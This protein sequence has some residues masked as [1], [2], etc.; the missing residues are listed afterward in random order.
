MITNRMSKIAINGLDQLLPINGAQLTRRKVSSENER[1]ANRAIQVGEELTSSLKREY[2]L[3][4]KRVQTRY[5]SRTIRTH[6]SHQ[7][8]CVR[9]ANFSI[10][11]LFIIYMYLT[12]II[13]FIYYSIFYM[14]VFFILYFNI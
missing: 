13:S 12:L 3:K 1:D 7:L 10:F 5:E 9:N 4:V 6:N 2:S 8:F 14:N 11:F